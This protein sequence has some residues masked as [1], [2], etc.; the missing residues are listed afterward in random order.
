M[1]HIKETEK[2]RKEEGKNRVLMAAANWKGEWGGREWKA[3][4]A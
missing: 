3:Q 4:Q 2:P 1:L